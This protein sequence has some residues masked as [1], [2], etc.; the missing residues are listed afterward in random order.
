[1]SSSRDGR[2]LDGAGF[3]RPPQIR[4]PVA[5]F[6][7]R[8]GGPCVWAGENVPA[9]TLLPGM[10]RDVKN[11]LT[12]SVILAPRQSMRSRWPI[13]FSDSPSH[14]YQS[15]CWSHLAFTSPKH[16]GTPW[17]LTSHADQLRGVERSSLRQVTP[18]PMAL[19]RRQLAVCGRSCSAWAITAFLGLSGFAVP[20]IASPPALRVSV[21]A[22]RARWRI[23]APAA[24]CKAAGRR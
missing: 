22:V 13:S 15:G 23:P 6:Q 3:Q 9:P 2:L 1:M 4:C 21:E 24:A 11:L 7:H 16:Q 10:V 18:K 12:I 14:L 19:Q 5:R 20:D 17:R 8:I